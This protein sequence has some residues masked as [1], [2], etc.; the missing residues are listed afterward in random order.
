MDTVREDLNLETKKA[1]QSL[2]AEIGKQRYWTVDELYTKLKPTCHFNSKRDMA[3]SLKALGYKCRVIR[4][5]T[6]PTRC[7]F[8]GNPLQV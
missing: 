7:Y 2:I 3:F 8:I 4:L 5:N 1:I 6:T